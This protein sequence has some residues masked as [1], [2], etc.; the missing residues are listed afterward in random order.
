VQ[1]LLE[2]FQR[3]CNALEKCVILVR[4]SFLRHDCPLQIIH[5]T[6]QLLYG[7]PHAIVIHCGFFLRR[8]L[9]EI[10][11]LRQAPLVFI[12]IVRR[13]LFQRGDFVRFF[14]HRL[15]NFRILQNLSGCFLLLRTRVL[16]LYCF[17]LPHFL[18][19]FPS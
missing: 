19:A 9:A 12:Q 14:L 8:T 18:H 2:L 3:H 11:K 15:Q 6:E 16:L 5:N 17:V 10:V 1:Y 4:L 7:I 13:L